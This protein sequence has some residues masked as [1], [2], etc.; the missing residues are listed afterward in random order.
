[1]PRV[2]RGNKRRHRVKKLLNLAE[3][4]FLGRRSQFRRS[5]E[6]VRRA[7]FYSYKGRRL[8]KR[9]FRALWISRISAAVAENDMSYSRF[10]SALTKS[11]VGLNRKMLSE[12][13]IHD[14]SG[15]SQVVNAVRAQA[16]AH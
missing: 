12:V 5:S 1:M 4:Y 14:P 2:K 8:K 7:L 13:A 9:D 3:G 10:I 16:P 15:F 11:Q 6:T